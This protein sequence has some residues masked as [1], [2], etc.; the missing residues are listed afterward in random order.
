MKKAMQ[1]HCPNCGIEIYAFA[2]W[3]FSHGNCKCGCGHIS[4]VMDV[5]EYS[6]KMRELREKKF[7]QK[8]NN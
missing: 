8:P 2:V 5:S 4:E 3:D 6:R 7:A 1:D